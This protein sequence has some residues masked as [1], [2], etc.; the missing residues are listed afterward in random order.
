MV[1]PEPDC[2]AYRRELYGK[3][4]QVRKQGDCPQGHLCGR[5]PR[6][7]ADRYHRHNREGRPRR[8]KEDVHRADCRQGL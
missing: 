1:L 8:R 3:Q 7:P 6:S 2:R 4:H 5:E